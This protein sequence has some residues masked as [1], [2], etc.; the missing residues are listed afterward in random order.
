MRSRPAPEPRVGTC[1]VCNGVVTETY[2]RQYDAST[3]PMIIGPGSAHQFR[4]VSSGLGCV[5]CGIAYQKIPPGTER[6]RPV[7]TCYCPRED[8]HCSV[9]WGF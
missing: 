8:P 3:G 7:T 6:P 4:W 5:D 2:N 9:C 1:R